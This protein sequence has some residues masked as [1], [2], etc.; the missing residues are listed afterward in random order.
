MVD[1]R[2]VDL[3]IFSQNDLVKYAQIGW[4]VSCAHP[5][6]LAKTLDMNRS[7]GAKRPGTVP[8]CATKSVSHLAC[9]PLGWK[10]SP[11]DGFSNDHPM[12]FSV[13]YL[14]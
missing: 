8:R 13:S 3:V 5:G 9:H 1:L 10:K 7:S 4:L 11:V 6:T 14:S 2:M 12:I